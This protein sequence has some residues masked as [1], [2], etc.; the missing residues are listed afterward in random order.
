MTYLKVHKTFDS[1]CNTL[2]GVNVPGILMDC[3]WFSLFLLVA[4]PIQQWC[5]MSF[6]RASC[7]CYVEITRRVFAH[8][9]CSVNTPHR[10]TG[11]AVNESLAS[12]YKY[13]HARI[14][15]ILRGRRASHPD[16]S[17]EYTYLNGMEGFRVFAAS[18]RALPAFPR[19]SGRT[20]FVY[21]Y[22]ILEMA[23]GWDEEI[24]QFTRKLPLMSPMKEA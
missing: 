14:L 21:S 8:A 18:R 10:H 17:T 13:I 12:L 23:T 22:S 11:F 6:P 9:I 2:A 7:R 20:F 15:G 19:I 5:D 24:G 16:Q 4:R 1:I 3:F